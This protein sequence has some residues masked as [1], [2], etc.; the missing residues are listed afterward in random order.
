MW[1]LGLFTARNTI[2][3]TGTFRQWTRDPTKTHLNQKYQGMSTKYPTNSPY[4]GKLAITTIIKKISIVN[5]VITQLWFI[6]RLVL[7]KNL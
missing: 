7:I 1:G 4:N 3:T 6:K 5:L 2:S